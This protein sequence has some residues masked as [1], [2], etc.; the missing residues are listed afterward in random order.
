[1][2]NKKWLQDLAQGNTGERVVCEYLL[3]KRPQYGLAEYNNDSRYDFRLTSSTENDLTF[4]IK[5]DCYEYLKG[6]MTYNIFVETSCSNKPSGIMTSEADYF[7]YY[8]PYLEEAYFIQSDKLR[9]FVREHNEDDDGIEY[10]NRAGD[11]QRVEGVCIHRNYHRDIFNVVKIKRD[12]NI[13]KD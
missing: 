6:F 8:F 7:V 5:S 4:E 9:E 13:W 2:S 10:K 1:M 12:K 11:G 3:S